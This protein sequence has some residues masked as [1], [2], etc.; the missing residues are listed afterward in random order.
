MSNLQKINELVRDLT[1]VAISKSEARARIVEYHNLA[2]QQCLEAL[3]EEKKYLFNEGHKGGNL[4]IRGFNT[5][6]KESKEA[7]TKL[8]IE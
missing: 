8:R 1:K 3:G 5:H 2:V 4:E 7:I 6:L